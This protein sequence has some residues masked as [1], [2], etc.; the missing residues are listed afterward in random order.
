M[1]NAEQTATLDQV[2][3]GPARPVG[4]RV[5]WMGAVLLALMMLSWS[6]GFVGYRYAAEGSGV[7]LVTF[8]RFVVAA[9]LILPFVARTL[10]GISWREV[11][12]HIVVGL[13]GIAGFIA[14]IASSIQLGVAPGTSSLIANLLPLSIVLMAGF[15]PGQRTQGR[16][17]FGVALCIAG[18]LIAS[19]VSVEISRA[20][21]WAYS[22]PALAVLSLTAAT[23]Y[24]KRAAPDSVPAMTALFIQICATLPVFAGLALL[25]GSIVPVM[26]LRFGF[27]VLWLVVF[28]TLGGYGFYWLCL[29]RFS[30]QSVSGALF[31]TPP[32]TM[33]WASVQFGDPLSGSALLGVALTLLGLPFLRR[34]DQA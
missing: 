30:M 25:E 14:L 3:A 31:L 23:L 6:S 29:Q 7:M 21:V 26:T 8:W 2:D 11:R 15:I 4:R 22:L 13:L 10:P 17:W 12:Q 34:R 1:M 16:Q 33:I 28:A 9:L 18:M 20:S 24:Q 32:V 19:A 5:Q 27:S